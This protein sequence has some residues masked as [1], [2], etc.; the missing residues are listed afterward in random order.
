MACLDAFVHDPV[1]NKSDMAKRQRYR[2]DLQGSLARFEKYCFST[3][4]LL[5]SDLFLLGRAAHEWHQDPS[6]QQMLQSGIGPESTLDE[7]LPEFELRTAVE[8]ARVGGMRALKECARQLDH[9]A[10][11]H[12]L[13]L[14][15]RCS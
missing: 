3:F 2:W 6:V 5:R 7:H 12:A 1:I 9:V 11:A 15:A 4:L 10:S 14:G 13:V 8:R